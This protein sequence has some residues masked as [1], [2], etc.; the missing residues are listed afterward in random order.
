MK[1]ILLAILILAVNF[2]VYA[3]WECPSRLG[4]A[5]K[6]IGD[7]NFM[8]GAEVTTS[9]GWIKDN[10]AANAMLFLGLNYGKGPSSFYIEGGLKAWQR[11]TNKELSFSDDGG[12]TVT[13]K[14]D[15]TNKILPG[16]REA[17][18]RYSGS[19]STF[20]L[21]LQSAKGDEDYL[22]NER[23]VGANY[24][25]RTGNIKLNAIA[26]SVMQDFA[27]NG[28]FCTLG[29]LYN[30]IVVGRPR[31]YVGNDFGDTDFGMLS[32]SFMPAK[33]VDEFSNES[34]SSF[35]FDKIGGV[36][37]SE[38][39]SKIDNAVFTGGLYSELS[40]GGVQFKPEIL[41]Q[42]VKDNNA[43]I[44]NFSAEKLFQWNAS[45]ATRLYARYLGF[46][47]VSDGARPVNSFSNLFMG[48]VL[49]MD[50]LENPVLM[51]GI[52]HSFTAAKLSLKL[53]GVFQTKASA[54]GGSYGF[55]PDN[56]SSPLTKMKEFDFGVSKNFGKYVLANVSIGMLDYPNL[57]TTDF[58]LHYNHVQT[59]FGKLELRFTF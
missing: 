7:S 41:Y 28:R 13:Y 19:S 35:S 16:L 9:A 42:S 23:I 56:Y 18:Y 30:D 3:Q 5:L 47:S 11:G 39:G 25:Y 20:T 59:M 12:T 49:R 45:N 40:L 21:G 1:R 55:V 48:D 58:V 50:V 24:S 54:Y 32:F 34:S 2:C 27:R 33:K 53:Q 31:S 4:A 38:F 36:A 22:L 6:P 51:F 43:V 46:S 37:Y 52:K 57:E 15:K 29:Y 10:Y 26:G 14:S 8:L 17:F 44:Y